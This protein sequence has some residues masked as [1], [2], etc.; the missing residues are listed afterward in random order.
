MK[1]RAVLV[2]SLSLTPAAARAQSLDLGA[3]AGVAL[4]LGA[5]DA[6]TRAGDTTFGG[7]PL[8]LDATI[9]IAPG[10][11]AGALAVWTPTSPR[12]C[13]STSEC[14]SSVGHDAEVDALVRFRGPKF[15]R[16]RPEAEV[17]FGWSWSTRTIVDSDVTS[18]RRWSGPVLAHAALVPTFDLGRFLRLGVVLGTSLERSSTFTLE[19]PSL[20]RAGVPG[21]AFHGRFDL[22]ARLGFDLT[23]I[24]ER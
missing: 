4:P 5:F 11:A 12:L 22:A 1:L 15:W 19:G 10:V 23:E 6:T 17:G 13:G 16:I 20:H 2:L 14:L 8:G 24:L 18:T 7:T 9:A 3:R 21:A